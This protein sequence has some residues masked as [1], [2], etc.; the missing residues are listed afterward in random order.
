MLQG[1]DPREAF[2][3]YYKP[4][5]DQQDRLDYDVYNYRM[6]NNIKAE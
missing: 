1:Q 2:I 5:P 4:S 3:A 6:D